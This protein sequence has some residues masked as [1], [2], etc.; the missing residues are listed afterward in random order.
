MLLSRGR[1]LCDIIGAVSG[2]QVTACNV[3]ASSRGR[4]RR[5]DREQLANCLGSNGYDVDL[6]AVGEDGLS[7]AIEVA[8][9][10]MT[11]DR[12]LPRL[13]GIEIIRRLRERGIATPAL[14]L[15]AL[16]EVDGRVR[17][18]R[19]DGDAGRRGGRRAMGR[20]RDGHH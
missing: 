7:R 8:Y 2:G 13:D 5:S 17:G 20:C 19:A 9:V 15:S 16:G 4:R 14:I 11:V 18:L 1:R 3:A 6:P 10:A 12:L